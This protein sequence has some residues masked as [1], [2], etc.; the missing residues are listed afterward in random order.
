MNNQVYLRDINE[1]R[2]LIRK[3]LPYINRNIKKNFVDKFV[4]NASVKIKDICKNH[5]GV[6]MLINNEVLAIDKWI[7]KYDK[8]AARLMKINGSRPLTN[9]M[10]FFKIDTATYAYVKIGSEIRK[11]NTNV[12]NVLMSDRR[13]NDSDILLY[14]FGKYAYRHYRKVSNMIDNKN[15]LKSYKVYGDDSDGISFRSLYEILDQRG[16]DTIFLEDGIK[17]AISR[18]IDN[19]ISNGD[20]YKNRNIIYKTG[21][22]L[23][24][25]PGTGKTSLI[26]AL[27][28]KYNYN[29]ITIDMTTF[30]LIALDTFT[31]SINI[32]DQK[33][34]IALEDIDCI[35][36][37][38]EDKSIDKDDKKVVN[39]LL[40][41]LDS[42]SSPNNVIFIATTNHIELLDPALLREGR[43]DLKVNI[44]GIKEKK[45]REMCKSFELSDADT[46]SIIEEI[47]NELHVDLVNETIR[48]SRLQSLILK[49]S[50]FNIRGEVCE[51]DV[52]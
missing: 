42:N 27:A 48:Q 10:F 5:F 34:I 33:Y 18:H 46:D 9:N 36:A 19:Y 25:E 26:K 41:F 3:A 6:E 4:H 51:E 11:A 15:V 47:K 38:R 28:N 7:T 49:R 35:I 52:E 20:L 12:A 14:I 1:E 30:D 43:F 37:N 24:G 22:L 16:M 32:D 8:H 29:L 23:Y 44:G 39:K 17:E 2:N 21:I 45:A 31:H 40:Q 13:I 50:G